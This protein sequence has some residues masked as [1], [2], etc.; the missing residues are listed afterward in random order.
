M[1]KTILPLLLVVAMAGVANA[2][3]TGTGTGFDAASWV[4]NTPN[5][6]SSSINVTGTTGTIVDISV[7]INDFNHTWL[8]DLNASLSNGTTTVDLFFR[9]GRD[10]AVGGFG[11]D[12]E[13]SGDF[14]FS[15][16][17]TD[18]LWNESANAAAGSQ[19]LN[20]TGFNFSTFA[21]D[22]VPT[23]MADFLGQSKDGVW[24]LTLGDNAGGDTGSFGGWTLNISSTVIPEPTTFGL[25]VGL[26][27]LAITRR[28]R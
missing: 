25:I 3:F 13:I 28:R 12:V 6:M 5:G 23:S 20:G 22:N 7:T 1:R 4:D 21:E 14:T 24:T 2:D 9:P 16:N 10:S 15:V 17:G 26:A 18:S 8:G 19:L 27:G 11:D